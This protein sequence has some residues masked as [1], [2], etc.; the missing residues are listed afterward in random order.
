[1]SMTLSVVGPVRRNVRG[2]Q[3]W[4]DISLLE[5]LSKESWLKKYLG[6]ISNCSSLLFSL[7]T[8]K[9]TYPVC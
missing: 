5:N 4:Y 1:M 3:A 8:G 2:K 6:N 9:R 7:Y